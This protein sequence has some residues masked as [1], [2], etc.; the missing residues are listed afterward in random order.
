MIQQKGGRMAGD[1]VLKILMQ[2]VR[3]LELNLSI[4]ERYLEELIIQYGDILS[5][6]EKELYE[7]TLYLHQIREELNHL[8]KYKK[9][10]VC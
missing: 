6:L 9:M 4:L 2:K 5:D 1:T 8:Q 7:N 10:M 3:S